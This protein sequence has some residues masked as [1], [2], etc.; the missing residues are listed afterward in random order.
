[1]GQRDKRRA[2]AGFRETLSLDF[3]DRDASRRYLAF[4]LWRAKIL[5][6]AL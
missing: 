6:L 4:G 1:M 5:F 3:E 2:G